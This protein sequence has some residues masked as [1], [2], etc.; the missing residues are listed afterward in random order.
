MKTTISGNAVPD[1]TLWAI[2]SAA[3]AGI[4]IVIAPLPLNLLAF[5]GWILLLRRSTRSPGKIELNKSS[6]P[7]HDEI[8]WLST[9]KAPDATHPRAMIAAH[10]VIVGTIIVVAGCLPVKQIDQI[11]NR[12][13]TLPHATMTLGEFAELRSTGNTHHLYFSLE[14]EDEKRVIHFPGT[15]MRLGEVIETIERQ[16]RFRRHVGKCGNESTILWGS[17]VTTI[18]MAPDRPPGDRDSNR[19]FAQASDGEGA[20]RPSQGSIAQSVEPSSDR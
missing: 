15:R 17:C 8:D 3:F 14:P 19:V 2:V 16:A 5:V 10:V 6:W 12:S 11:L 13:I 18:W 20:R 9:P 4:V 7:E 1:R